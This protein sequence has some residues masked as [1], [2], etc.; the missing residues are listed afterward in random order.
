MGRYLSPYEERLPDTAR[1]ILGR[2]SRPLKDDEMTYAEKEQLIESDITGCGRH[3]DAVPDGESTPF[4]RREDLSA[5]T[6]RRITA[7]CC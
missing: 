7:T 5:R 4:V 6:P 1:R 2:G 3:I